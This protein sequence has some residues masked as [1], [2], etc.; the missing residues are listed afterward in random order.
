MD[1]DCHALRVLRAHGLPQQSLNDVFR[2]TV[3][4]KLLY[5]ASAWFGYCTAGDKMRL[6]SFLC[7]CWKLGYSDRNMTFEDI[8]A[9]AD[10]QLFNRLIHNPNHVLHRLLPPSNTASQRYNFRTRRHTLQLL[11]HHTSLQDSNFL[12]R[13]LYKDSY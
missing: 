11:E 12:L 1:I 10:E 8:C 9:D 3:Q 2:A 7:K 4:G 5:A 6:N 13:M